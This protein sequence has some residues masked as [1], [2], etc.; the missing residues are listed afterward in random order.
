MAI[1]IYKD[2]EKL[3]NLNGNCMNDDE[4]HLF[5]QFIRKLDG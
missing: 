4:K 2:I 5:D 3:S 1:Y